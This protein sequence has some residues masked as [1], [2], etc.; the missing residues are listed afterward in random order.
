MIAPWAQEELSCGRLSGQRAERWLRPNHSC[1][2]QKDGQEC[3]LLIH[4]EVQG[5]YEPD[6]PERMFDYNTRARQLYN[7]L[8]FSPAVLTDDNPDR[9]EDGDWGCTVGILEGIG[10]ALENQIWGSGPPVVGPG[11][12]HPGHRPVAGSGPGDQGRSDP[13]RPAQAIEVTP[14]QSGSPGFSAEGI[15]APS[16]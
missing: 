6:F 2:W 3:W 15:H 5:E 4:I 7:R 13:G 12:A 9:F 1:V 10:L 8:V 16:P 11:P 14:P